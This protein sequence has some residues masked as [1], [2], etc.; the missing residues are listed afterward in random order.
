[1]KKIKFKFVLLLLAINIF[2]INSVISQ[3]DYNMAFPN[4]VCGMDNQGSSYSYPF[5]PMNDDTL[6]AL[7]VFCNFPYQSGNYDNGKCLLQYWPGTSAQTKPSW[8]DSVICPTTTNIWHPSLTGYF[9]DASMGK[10]L[11]IGDV[12]PKLYVFQGQVDDYSDTSRKIGYAV[13]ELLEGIDD[14]VNYADYDKFDPDDFDND[15]DYREPDGI[16]DFIFIIFRFTNAH[17]ID[18]GDTRE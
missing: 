5:F 15:G 9:R 14:E 10:F 1:M 16:V 17:T 13:K 2:V 18:P 11:L 8:A 4:L 7:V 6:K 3:V 12:Y